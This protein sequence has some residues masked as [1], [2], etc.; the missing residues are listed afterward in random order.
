MLLPGVHT[1][2]SATRSFWNPFDES[3]QRADFDIW[4][5]RGEP[6]GAKNI[7]GLGYFA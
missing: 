4:G 1:G 3:K 6:E 5:T 2:I 7:V